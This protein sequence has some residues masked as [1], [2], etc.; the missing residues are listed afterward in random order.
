MKT[1]T[2]KRLVE[3]LDKIG[4]ALEKCGGRGG[5]PGPCPRGS[6]Q[7]GGK[8]PPAKPTKPAAG[9]SAK[10]AKLSGGKRPSQQVRNQV[11]KVRTGQYDLN[12]VGGTVKYFASQAVS[13]VDKAIAKAEKFVGKLETGK[14]AAE[15]KLEAVKAQ[16]SAVVK[17]VTKRISRVAGLFTRLRSLAKSASDLDM[18]L[19]NELDKLADAIDKAHDLA[20]NAISI[21]E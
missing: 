2:K 20:D 18:T 5:T 21:L 11:A 19:A 13:V 3:V 14:A 1:A 12:T 9:T 16:K 4:E 8:K 10:P 15:K 7:G 17:E 6:G